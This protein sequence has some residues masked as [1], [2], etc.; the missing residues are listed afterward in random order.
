M[1]N[2]VPATLSIHTIIIIVILLLSTLQL[3]FPNAHKIF[4]RPKSQK[5]TCKKLLL[6]GSKGL[7]IE[8]LCT[9]ANQ[10]GG[11]CK[12]DGRSPAKKC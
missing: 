10:I 1:Q 4:V 8:C 2:F 6:Y 5:Y 11:G 3:P 12:S 7:V 9:T